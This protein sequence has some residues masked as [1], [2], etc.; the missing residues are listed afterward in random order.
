MQRM[1][2]P[3]RRAARVSFVLS[4]SALWLLQGQ[5]PQ[6]ATS[7][8]DPVISSTAQEVLLD[9]VAEVAEEPRRR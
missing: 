3:L 5:A 9:V 6:T 7:A 2:S 1:H 8:A 4:L